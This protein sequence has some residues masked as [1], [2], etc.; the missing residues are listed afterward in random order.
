MGVSL[1]ANMAASAAMMAAAS[2]MT[3]PQPCLRTAPV[4]AAH[5]N[6][7]AGALP[8]EDRRMTIPRRTAA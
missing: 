6:T 1:A 2:S 7:P 5:R 8:G 3:R 4:E